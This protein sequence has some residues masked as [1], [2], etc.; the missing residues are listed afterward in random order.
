MPRNFLPRAMVVPA[1][2]APAGFSPGLFAKRPPPC[3]AAPTLHRSAFYAAFSPQRP[4]CAAAH[5]MLPS[6]RSAY[7]AP[8]LC[9]WSPLL[10]R[11]ARP[12]TVIPSA[13]QPLP[14]FS[15]CRGSG[16][17]TAARVRHPARGGGGRAFVAGH[18]PADAL[19]LPVPPAVA[20]R[21]LHGPIPLLYLLPGGLCCMCIICLLIN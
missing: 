14:S 4:P 15:P 6:R 13:G 2:A 5:F 11:S 1:A 18:A 3:A 19:F 16:A 7:P 21:S 17:R 12:A 8:R 9:L 20:L 10:R